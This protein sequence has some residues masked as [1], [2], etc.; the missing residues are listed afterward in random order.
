MGDTDSHSVSEWRIG[1]VVIRKLNETQE[2]AANTSVKATEKGSLSHDTDKVNFID[3]PQQGAIHGRRLQFMR[4]N[5]NNNK[6]IV[7]RRK[8]ETPEMPVAN[9]FRQNSINR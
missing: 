6:V 1:F 5:N 4:S 2:V 8:T 9:T 3:R 7:R